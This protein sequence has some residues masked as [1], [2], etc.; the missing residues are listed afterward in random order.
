[1]VYCLRAKS[2]VCCL[3]GVLSPIVLRATALCRGV[4]ATDGVPSRKSGARAGALGIDCSTD[5]S[6]GSISTS[7][8][9]EVG[10]SLG[11][12]DILTR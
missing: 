4:P 10:I 6:S 3:R 9:S 12:E 2:G 7:S 5:A 8:R 1:M 11:G